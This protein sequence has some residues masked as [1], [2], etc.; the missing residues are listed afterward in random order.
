ML[1][2]D[3]DLFRD[4]EWVASGALAYPSSAIEWVP[5]LSYGRLAPR[6]PQRDDIAAAKLAVDR[7]VE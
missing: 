6:H 5:G 4:L 1:P 2:S 3:V 7:K